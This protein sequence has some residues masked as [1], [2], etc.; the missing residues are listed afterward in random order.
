ME[1]VWYYYGININCNNNNGNEGDFKMIEDK[2]IVILYSVFGIILF[3]FI[4]LI[5]TIIYAVYFHKPKKCYYYE[6]W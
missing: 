5:L 2:L 4:V 6:N 3:Y 1:N